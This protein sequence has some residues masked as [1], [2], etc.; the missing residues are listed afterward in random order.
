[1]ASYPHLCIVAVLV[2][3]CVSVRC[4]GRFQVNDDDLRN[5][6]RPA[7]PPAVGPDKPVDEI[8]AAFCQKGDLSR[9]DTRERLQRLLEP[10]SGGRGPR[11]TR[12]L[13]LLVNNILHCVPRDVYAALAPDMIS[14]LSSSLSGLDEPDTVPV[15]SSIIAIVMRCELGVLGAPCADYADALAT[16]AARAPSLAHARMIKPAQ[17]DDA[18]ATAGDLLFPFANLVGDSFIAGMTSQTGKPLEGYSQREAVLFTARLL[19]AVAD[20]D[21]AAQVDLYRRLTLAAWLSQYAQVTNANS[22]GSAIVADVV[23]LLL[24]FNGA[25]SSIVVPIGWSPTI[26]SPGHAMMMDLALL[27]SGRV[28]VRIFNAGAGSH[29]HA[30]VAHDDRLSVVPVVVFDEVDPDHI[31]ESDLVARLVA[32]C[33]TPPNQV[34]TEAP[35][36]DVDVYDVVLRRLHPYLVA[37]DD[38][39]VRT[40]SQLAGTCTFK[41]IKAVLLADL[42]ADRFRLVKARLERQALQ[43]CQDALSS[44]ANPSSID[45]AWAFVLRLAMQNQARRAVK[46][47]LDDG[48]GDG[49][50]RALI[51][52]I[53]AAHA[54]LPSFDP[55]VSQPL[56]PPSAGAASCPTARRHDAAGSS[57]AVPPSSSPISLVGDYDP[58]R[59]AVD[60]YVRR[61]ASTYAQTWPDDMELLRPNA[62]TG[63]IL[64]L[65]VAN[66]AAF[67]ALA[68]PAGLIDALVALFDAIWSWGARGAVNVEQSA[69]QFDRAVA[70][71]QVYVLV[72]Q[73]T[74]A[75]DARLG[76]RSAGLAQETLDV[77]PACRL[78]TSRTVLAYDNTYVDRLQEVIAL[79]QCGHAA[80]SDPFASSGLHRAAKR[81]VERSAARLPSPT[82]EQDR[83]FPDRHGTCSPARRVE[84][85]LA[86][87][88]TVGPLSLRHALPLM[89]LRRKLASYALHGVRS[90]PRPL[91]EVDV[92][93]IWEGVPAA[94]N[95][96]ACY[97][98]VERPPMPDARD[99]AAYDDQVYA[100]RGLRSFPTA[101]AREITSSA[102][103]GATENELRVQWLASRVPQLTTMFGEQTTLAALLFAWQNGQV[104][105]TANEHRHW[106][107]YVVFR[108][109]SYSPSAGVLDA[110]VDAAQ[111]DIQRLRRLVD[112]V[113]ST[114]VAIV[115]LYVLSF[116][117]YRR[118]RRD[119]T[120]L[121]Q[122]GLSGLIR[123]NRGWAPDVLSL[124][125]AAL[126]IGRSLSPTLATG[127]LLLDAQARRLV[128]VVPDGFAHVDHEA[129]MVIAAHLP[130]IVDGA[131][132]AAF[133]QAVASARVSAMADDDVVEYDADVSRWIVSRSWQ[134]PTATCLGTS[135]GDDDGAAADCRLSLLVPELQCP[136]FQTRHL[137]A[138]AELT[139]L[140]WWRAHLERFRF[141]APVRREPLAPVPTYTVTPADASAEIWTSLTV[142][143]VDG[144]FK[145]P[146]ASMRVA[147]LDDDFVLVGRDHA[148]GCFEH[149]GVVANRDGGDAYKVWMRATTPPMTVITDRTGTGIARV[150]HKWRGDATYQFYPR[151]LTCA[152]GARLREQRFQ[153]VDLDDDNFRAVHRVDAY[154]SGT[155]CSSTRTAA[156]LPD[157]D[158]RANLFR[159]TTTG[160]HRLVY[161][162]LA[163]DGELVAFNDCDGARGDLRWESD[164]TLMLSPDQS[165][166]GVNGGHRMLILQNVQ[167]A[168]ARKALLTFWVAE[169]QQ[170][171]EPP[172]AT[173][174]GTR[175]ILVDL[176]ERRPDPGGRV[177]LLRPSSR[178]QALLVVYHEMFD[179]RYERAMQALRTVHL[180][181]PWT[182]DERDLVQV[183]V[184][185][186]DA[187]PEAVAVRTMTA[188]LDERMAFLHGPRSRALPDAQDTL[189]LYVQHVTTQSNLPLA[190]R[191]VASRQLAASPDLLLESDQEQRLLLRWLDGAGGHVRRVLLARLRWLADDVTTTT[192]TTTDATLYRI[193][194][195]RDQD[196][197]GSVTFPRRNVARYAELVEQQAP[198]NDD[199][200]ASRCWAAL[201][202][203]GASSPA[204][205]RC[206]IRLAADPQST[207]TTGA[208]LLDW[209]RL[210]RRSPH[211]VVN[212]RVVLPVDGE[213]GWLYLEKAEQ[214]EADLVER[215]V[216]ARADWGLAP[217]PD[218]ASACQALMDRF[219][220]RSLADTDDIAAPVTRDTSTLEFYATPDQQASD[221]DLI[222]R[223]RA[224]LAP[225]A[226]P[227]AARPER[228]VAPAD[229]TTRATM[230]GVA[231]IEGD[232]RAL[233]AQYLSPV[234]RPIQAPTT[235][236]YAVDGDEHVRRRSATVRDDLEQG[237]ATL[238][239]TQTTYR[240]VKPEWRPVLSSGLTKHVATLSDMFNS[241]VV[242]VVG[243]VGSHPSWDVGYRPGFDWQALLPLLSS[244]TRSRYRTRFPE[245]ADDDVDGLHASLVELVV[246]VTGL[247]HAERC[248]RL[249]D[250]DETLLAQALMQE[251]LPIDEVV[252]RPFLAV[253]EASADVRLRPDQVGDLLA[254]I[255]PDPST[256]PSMVLQRLMGGGK[257][258]VLG[259]LLALTKADGYHLSVMVPP[260]SLFELN[261]P[262]IM[263]RSTRFFG[264]GASVVVFEPSNAQVA[265]D[266]L[267]DLYDTL[268][269]AI[270][271]GRY[272]LIAPASL[273]CMENTYIAMA[274]AADP[275]K[276]ESLALLGA[277]MRL[278]SER[279]AVTFDEIDMTLDPRREYNLPLPGP[280][281]NPDDV[282]ARLTAHLFLFMATGH[283]RPEHKAMV[284]AVGLHANRQALM[285]R[286]T[287]DNDVLPHLI[288]QSIAYLKAES[289]SSS[290]SGTS[291]SDADMTTILS[292][293]TGGLSQFADRVHDDDFQRLA[294][295]HA[296]LHDMIPFALQGSVSQHYGRSFERPHDPIPVPYAAANTPSER[297]EFANRWEVVN[298]ACIMHVAQGLSMHEARAF[299]ESLLSDAFDDVDRQAAA[300]SNVRALI[301]GSAAGQTF[302]QVKGLPAEMT[303]SKV[304]PNK[305]AHVGLVCT[306]LRR[307][308]NV[309][310]VMAFVE[311]HVLGQIRSVTQQV[312]GNAANLASMFASVQ[313]YSGTI[314]NLF[315]FPHR[316]YARRATAVRADP[317]ANGQ[318]LMRV[319]GQ[320]DALVHDVDAASDVTDLVG[321]DVHACALIDIGAF[322]KSV[323]NEDVSRRILDATEPGRVAG[324]LYFDER[325][326]R[327][328]AM[329]R[330]DPD[331]PVTLPGSDLATI[332][333]RTGLAPD[334]LFTYYDHRHITG[335]D[336]VQPAAG[337]A[338]ATFSST[339]PLRD[340]LQGVMRMRRF[341]HTQAV[342]FLVADLPGRECNVAG[343]LR[344]AQRVQFED[345][346]GQNRQAALQK[347]DDAV[348]RRVLRVAFRDDDD[349]GVGSPDIIA[350]ADHVIVRVLTDDYTGRV[351]RAQTEVLTKAVLERH[352]AALLER[353]AD[354]VPDATELKDELDAIVESFPMPD[355][356]LLQSDL[357]DGASPQGNV[358]EQQ[359]EQ[360]VEVEVE[361]DVE[362]DVIVPGIAPLV[363]PF[364]GGFRQQVSCEATT[365]FSSLNDELQRA[366]AATGSP[367]QVALASARLFAD[368]ILATARFLTTR[369]EPNADDPVSRYRK[370]P[371]EMAVAAPHRRGRL[372]VV[373]SDID[374]LNELL[375]STGA[376]HDGSPN[377]VCR[378]V[379]V[380]TP[381]GVSET[382]DRLAPIADRHMAAMNRL[383]LD[384]LLY[385][386]AFGAVDNRIVAFR[387]GAAD[388]PVERV[389]GSTTHLALLKVYFDD[390]LRM[391]E[392]Q[393]RQWGRSLLREACNQ[394]VQGMTLD[395][396][397][398]AA[399]AKQY[400]SERIVDDG[401]EDGDG[402]AA[403]NTTTGTAN[404]ITIIIVTVIAAAIVV[405]VGAAIAN[406]R[407]RRSRA[408]AA[409]AA[410]PAY[411]S[412]TQTVE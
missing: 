185:R 199:D 302:R 211:V 205:V 295:I 39:V 385:Y 334:R 147:G 229:L 216:Y 179:R 329:M 90:V 172:V 321:V 130:G 159:S 282:V 403:T 18:V 204:T 210:R 247:Q 53:E 117:L 20:A 35:F 212:D 228:V 254:L 41:S 240:F 176:A 162:R 21:D 381:T 292:A 354:L 393:R 309:G 189:R 231:Q 43:V 107:D 362:Q 278:L 188:L 58:A 48:D 8:A 202:R 177:E 214:L 289:S 412:P 151:C 286:H 378:H 297:S 198:D 200:D 122:D 165:L 150:E 290:S 248:L 113:P 164:P 265:V 40:R 119:T 281:G 390:V 24:R 59:G 366:A 173:M 89:T 356:R 376:D 384:V 218:V 370:T 28:R 131:P 245:L 344:S 171:G 399:L 371:F 322:F 146:V 223:A 392:E 180:M 38:D 161:A 67:N 10:A 196:N 402:D 54:R 241:K 219:R 92:M 193:R 57:P 261:A 121:C 369:Q 27:P 11:R 29:R 77:A 285:P 140:N 217:S 388:A 158:V 112:T 224:A 367:V 163:V 31:F 60:A 127:A 313:G 101:I 404:T 191:L 153:L 56:P 283:G 3:Y 268:V 299:I 183:I 82:K 181:S 16:A 83:L 373:L 315:V 239:G 186:V 236:Q 303:L 314:E 182:D 258:F 351:V 118:L 74:L 220:A 104:D 61:L 396:G 293:A 149:F 332:T 44:V 73:A 23:H 338:L 160:C 99:F 139:A 364:V 287:Y 361:I 386:G 138:G 63:A 70:L 110:L 316:V 5:L 319:I 348:R 249:V 360:H 353:S 339:T 85:L 233:A 100:A 64:S 190:M 45:L 324:V 154:P 312:V 71:A 251:R 260:A 95:P 213:G 88:H 103:R 372:L 26:K 397:T 169:A 311:T 352:V 102:A 50:I 105:A 80:S 379:H 17:L 14:L 195:R 271:N 345:E 141:A 197:R 346:R 349:G 144:M 340:L 235:D 22:L 409:A 192:T 291:F 215:A 280:G 91:D 230:A 382:S 387:G 170:E 267:R 155:R 97:A 306:A 156:A 207:K 308:D 124:A 410:A 68:D 178:C 411:P 19:G 279:G 94:P 310:L 32:L 109:R 284:D 377:H 206:L 226:A 401:D 222:R 33:T 203:A 157:R 4:A 76:D 12:S 273:H 242:D 257:T 37:S 347:I 137:G 87:F 168:R 255:G 30:Q 259:T 208:R 395:V 47:G 244:G 194:I 36:D 148:A 108:P 79:G 327:L 221:E 343:M 174:D 288:A 132:D 272:V 301:D 243:R 232:I 152:Q 400:A 277:I 406:W 342:R 234:V 116:R 187:V 46:N 75:A 262:E 363:A 380:V 335:A 320:G 394:A 84:L 227:P 7:V 246:V 341:L 13:V 125:H 389:L 263:T 1:M 225:L 330:A 368:N 134:C 201:P 129:D 275:A 237:A 331:R 359:V 72:W 143:F 126:V 374:E 106:I 69:T 307:L 238:V 256:F 55:A 333:A 357:L 276:R 133:L 298:R 408:R 325:T 296:Q 93:D 336:I 328:R 34:P 111:A 62:L 135:G 136:G 300:G 6:F 65:P 355:D 398:I 209:A 66:Q 128:G 323:R 42:G 184:A 253:F 252:R 123:W 383:S 365:A 166:G 266:R 86:A 98:G 9:D 326:N 250:G 114:R 142:A 81:L 317:G 145:D 264:Q 274:R 15:V 294:L 2:L 358:V 391:G 375:T 25:L 337:V 350:R 78:L 407:G 167:D 52:K 269:A 304:D 270:A 405:A 51:D 305:E 49:D 120:A 175:T 318:V 115:Y 96:S